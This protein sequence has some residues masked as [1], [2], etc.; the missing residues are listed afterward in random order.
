MTYFLLR[1]GCL[2]KI[3]SKQDI[4]LNRHHKMVLRWSRTTGSWSQNALLV[5]IFTHYYSGTCCTTIRQTQS[6][7]RGTDDIVNKSDD[8]L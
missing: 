7:A 6:C 5:G 4:L 3:S 2:Q 1:G 8:S